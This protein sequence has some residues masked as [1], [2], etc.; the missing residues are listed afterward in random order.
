MTIRSFRDDGT[1][2]IAKGENSKKARRTVPQDLIAAVRTLEALDAAS[3]L[4]DLQLP[5]LRLEA[6]SGELAGFYSI[7]VNQKYRVIFK[8]ENG[9]ATDVEIIDYH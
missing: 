3:M 2:D 6:L 9:E 5:G 1:R 7:R 8:F 4:T